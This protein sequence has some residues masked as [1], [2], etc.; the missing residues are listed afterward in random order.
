MLEINL[1]NRK[2]EA[3][4]NEHKQFKSLLPHVDDRSGSA[5][6]EKS[7]RAEQRGATEIGYGLKQSY[8]V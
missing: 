3:N 5:H 8:K 7:V 4:I 1:Q 2:G 6:R